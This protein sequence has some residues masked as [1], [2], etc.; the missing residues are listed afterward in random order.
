MGDHTEDWPKDHRPDSRTEGILRE[1]FDCARCK[2]PVTRLEQDLSWIRCGI[3]MH[4]VC[5]VED[6]YA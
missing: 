1:V 6:A 4:E 5:G 2:Q 3:R